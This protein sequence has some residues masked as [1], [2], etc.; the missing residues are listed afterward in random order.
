MYSE[1]FIA[2]KKAASAIDAP[3]TI[4][5]IFAL[6]LLNGTGIDI[7]DIDKAIMWFTTAANSGCVDSMRSLCKVYSTDA[8]FDYKSVPHFIL[9]TTKAA[10]AGCVA[11]M[12]I[13]SKIYATGTVFEQ[14]DVAKNSSKEFKWTKLRADAGCV[15]ALERLYYMYTD[16]TG[17][18]QD[19]VKAFDAIKKFSE[20]EGFYSYAGSFILAKLYADGIGVDKDSV[21]AFELVKLCVNNAGYNSGNDY[22]DEAKVFLGLMYLKGLGTDV[23]IDQAEVLFNDADVD[24]Y[25]CFNFHYEWAMA[26]RYGLGVEKDLDKAMTMFEYSENLY[27]KNDDDSYRAKSV[28]ELVLLNQVK[29]NP[30]AIKW[31]MLLIQLGHESAIELFDELNNPKACN[32]RKRISEVNEVQDYCCKCHECDVEIEGIGKAYKKN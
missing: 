17:T 5:Y 19:P 9:W 16:G 15:S 21:K 25:S 20:L 22:P 27:M 13:L 24:D 7:P 32:K 8:W 2:A 30:N 10:T 26:Y 3:A 29:D 12:E 4:M 6:M 18:D 28:Y 31:C 23:D 14:D 11:S 1:S